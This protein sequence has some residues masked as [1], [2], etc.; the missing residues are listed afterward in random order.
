VPDQHA[1]AQ[2]RHRGCRLDPLGAGN[3]FAEVDDGNGDTSYIASDTAG[4]L[5]MFG[6]A[7]LSFTPQTVHAVQVT[8]RAR[9]DD[10]ATR[11]VRSKI[12][13]DAATSDGATRTLTSSYL[14][15]HDV[16]EEDPDAAGPWAGAAV[17]AMEI[18][19][20]TVT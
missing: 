13:S 19:V 4:D 3:H 14:Y 17:A 18:G 16:F 10:A 1:P 20:E 11:E 8:W 7:A 12:R 6:V 15:Y 2:C 5:D 9:K